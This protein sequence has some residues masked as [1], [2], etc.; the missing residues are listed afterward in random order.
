MDWDV[1]VETLGRFV[2]TDTIRADDLLFGGG[3]DITSIS[4]IEFIMTLE[5][6]YDREIDID[7]LDAGI[8][9]VGD[10]FA[11]LSGADPAG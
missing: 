5:E 11:R 3:L 9:T 7:D 1:F 4:F 2:K 10:L 6:R 8:R